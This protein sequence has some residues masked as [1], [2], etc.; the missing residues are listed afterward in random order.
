MSNKRSLLDP[1]STRP[2]FPSSPCPVSTSPA[3]LAWLGMALS[4][5]TCGQALDRPSKQFFFPLNF[6]VPCVYAFF[7]PLSA[8][9]FP[10]CGLGISFSPPRFLGG[11]LVPKTQITNRVIFLF[12]LFSFFQTLGFLV[13]PP[14]PVYFPPRRDGRLMVCTPTREGCLSTDDTPD[15]NFFLLLR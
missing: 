15:S 6:Y 7:S 12:P 8:P 14:F 3:T 4:L 1:F 9:P 11:V 13:F 2:F 5:Q 10:P